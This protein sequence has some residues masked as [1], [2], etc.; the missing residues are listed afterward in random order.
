MTK[1]TYSPRR[2]LR[3]A[4]AAPYVLATKVTSLPPHNVFRTL[5]PTEWY[6]LNIHGEKTFPSLRGYLPTLPPDELQ[7]RFTGGHGE[8]TLREAFSFYRTVT[9][10]ASSARPRVALDFGH[11]SLPND[12]SLGHV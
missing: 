12:Q 8:E 9:R 5:A 10:A 2:W 6:W 7:V 4:V 3:P 11:R 1:F